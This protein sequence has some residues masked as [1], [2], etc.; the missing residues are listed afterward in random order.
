LLNTTAVKRTDYGPLTRHL[1]FL[2][3]KRGV[4]RPVTLPEHFATFLS[5]RERRVTADVTPS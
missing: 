4:A 1:F 5:E 2:T 3:Q